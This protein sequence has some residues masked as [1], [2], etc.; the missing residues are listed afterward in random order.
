MQIFWCMS[1][2]LEPLSLAAQSLIAQDSR[3]ADRAQRWSWTVLGSGLVLGTMVTGCL[4]AL[5]LNMSWVF[6]SDAV[7]QQ[8]MGGLVAVACLAMLLCAPMMMLDGISVGS[9][10]FKHIPASVLV[11][12]AATLCTLYLAQQNQMGLAGVWWAL[13]AFYASRLA[14]HLLHYWRIWPRSVFR[15]GGRFGSLAVAAGRLV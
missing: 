8:G 1:F 10:D 4:A 2:L 11:G 5:Y 7:V 6:T 14:G 15:A 3:R 13:N 12:S 9:A